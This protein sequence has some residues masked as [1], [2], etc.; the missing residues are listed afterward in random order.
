ML[1]ASLH[2]SLYGMISPKRKEQLLGLFQR[3]KRDLGTSTCPD[4]ALVYRLLRN[5]ID[6]FEIQSN[7]EPTTFGC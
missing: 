7:I 1:D 6:R 3:L 4:G 5:L 2:P